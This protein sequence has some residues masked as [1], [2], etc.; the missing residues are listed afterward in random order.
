MPD[1]SST[2]I[3]DLLLGLIIVLFVPFGIRRGAA[4]EA[5]GSAGLL[6]GAAFADA[7]ASTV[8][9][10]L[11]DLLGLS[12]PTAS[13]VVTLGFLLI[14]MFVIG[15][16][17]G[18]ALGRTNPGWLSRIVGGVIAALNAALLL[19]LSLEA[20]QRNLQTDGLLADGVVSGL[21]MNRRDLLLLGA[22]CA[23]LVFVVGGW[24]VNLFRGDRSAQ[25]SAALG[26]RERPVRTPTA[27]D[28][29]K[30]E[31]MPAR[32]TP[33]MSQTAPIPNPG[34]PWQRPS[35]NGG[36]A[37]APVN[38][39]MSWGQQAGDPRRGGGSSM[40]TMIEVRRTCPTCGATAAATDVFCQECGKTL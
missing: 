4:K 28:Q 39:W 10:W 34:D 26:R 18:A 9:R 20:V 30:Y 22:V 17:G 36:Q 33:S 32:P 29:G 23:M 27:A 5:M 14:G 3:L 2:L 16:G 13:F 15:Y 19:S 21:L 24:I 12:R 25:D 35:G 40:E 1:L 11:S 38:P 7:W 31:P 37:A 8:A 6:L